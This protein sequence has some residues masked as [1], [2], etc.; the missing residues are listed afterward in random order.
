MAFFRSVPIRE[1]SPKEKYSYTYAVGETY[2]NSAAFCGSYT[3]ST[4][5]SS[6]LPTSQYSNDIPILR[7]DFNSPVIIGNHVESCVALLCQ[8][9]TFNSPIQ[10][11]ET[12]K[13]CAYMLKNCSLY[14]IPFNIPTGIV[15]A[16]SM[17][18]GLT[19][20][21]QYMNVVGLSHLENGS[22]MF[23]QLETAQ[24]LDID[25]NF[26]SLQNANR[27]FYGCP[28]RNINITLPNTIKDA[29]TMFRV[30]LP[31]IPE[32]NSRQRQNNCMIGNIFIKFNPSCN[33]TNFINFSFTLSSSKDENA[34]LNIYSNQINTSWVKAAGQTL[35]YSNLSSGHGVYNERYGVYLYNNYGG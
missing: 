24:A 7:K 32:L 9:N 22:N 16:A 5:D 12:L 18:Y 27:M 17:C 21:A 19:N 20:F 29:S 15:N 23:Y 31:N 10:F 11:S 2:Y 25:C 14:N 1:E 6:I 4:V 26:S 3:G 34:K 13:N 8:C 28:I 33:Y 35:S 30:F